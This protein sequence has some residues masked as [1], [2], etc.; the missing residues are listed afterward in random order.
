MERAPGGRR[1]EIATYGMTPEQELG[2]GSLA[3]M[4]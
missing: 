4:N 2:S 3:N 1:N